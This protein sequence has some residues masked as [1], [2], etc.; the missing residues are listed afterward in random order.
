MPLHTHDGFVFS[1]L[2][3]FDDTIRCRCCH[4]E[5]G[6]GVGDSLM[7]EGVDGKAQWCFTLLLAAVVRSWGVGR[8]NFS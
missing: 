4:T 6:T 8:I 1:A 2:N 3:S 5:A 7:V